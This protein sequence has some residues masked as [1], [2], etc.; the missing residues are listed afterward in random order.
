MS[1]ATALSCMTIPG[2]LLCR[3]VS[4]SLVRQ[5]RR[6]LVDHHIILIAVVI[7]LSSCCCSSGKHCIRHNGALTSRPL[8]VSNWPGP[9]GSGEN[10]RFRDLGSRRFQRVPE[11]S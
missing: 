7:S 2:I 8:V 3:E 4:L 5:Y 11:A 1:I 9:L 10:S 6:V